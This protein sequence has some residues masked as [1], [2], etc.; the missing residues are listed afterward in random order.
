MTCCFSV[1]RM[2]VDRLCSEEALA[3]EA[4]K[5]QEQ[6]RRTVEMAALERE[7][8]ALAEQT[9][10]LLAETRAVEMAKQAVARSAQENSAK[11]TGPAECVICLEGVADHILLPCLHLC[12]CSNDA[13]NFS[14]GSLCP[15]CRATVDTVNRVYV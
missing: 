14:A 4:E 9:Q 8:K 15:I 11:L 13:A 10:Q 5:Q 3:R 1:L 12:L 6:H 7:K 2:C